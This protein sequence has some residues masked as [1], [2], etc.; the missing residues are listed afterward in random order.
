MF[1]F[2]GLFGDDNFAQKRESESSCKEV[3]KIS[4]ENKKNFEKVS[5]LFLKS[6]CTSNRKH[7]GDLPSTERF[8]HL[9]MSAYKI[10]PYAISVSCGIRTIMYDKLIYQ[11]V[12]YQEIWFQVCNKPKLSTHLLMNCTL[13]SLIISQR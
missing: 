4:D 3:T 5:K 13:L 1:Q 11:L 12:I 6:L 8:Y 7:S 10:N 9:H 2:F